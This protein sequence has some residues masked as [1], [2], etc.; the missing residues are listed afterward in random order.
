MI[1]QGMN[2]VDFVAQQIE[3]LF[4]EAEIF[5]LKLF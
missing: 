3:F 4:A 5:L 2:P 1:R